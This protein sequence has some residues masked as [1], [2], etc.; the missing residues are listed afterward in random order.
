MPDT[1]TY[2]T[3]S[4]A[5]QQLANRL[6]DSNQV[7]W[8]PAELTSIHTE[9]LRTWNALT[10]FWRGDFIFSTQANV[11]WYDLTDVTNLP[12][13][14]RPFTLTDASLYPD[15]QFALLEPAVGVNPWIG[16]STQ[17][18][19]ADL[20]SALQRRR[21]EI[22][23]VTGC[24]TTKRNVGAV[25]G[26]IT[27]PD[28]VIDVRRMAYFPAIG[29]PSTMWPDDTWAEQSFAA[30]YLQLPAGTPFA[31]LLSTEPPIS[32][33]TDRAPNAAGSYE[34]LTVESGGAVTP[35][36][37]TPLFI[38]DDWAHVLKWGVLA[39][40]LGRESNAKDSL[41][42]GYCEQRY[43]MGLKLLAIAPAL[44]ALRIGNR[45]LQ[46]DSVRSADLYRA[47]WQAEAAG[48]PDMA[49]HSGLNLI[50]LAAKPDAGPYSLTATVVE[51]A[52]IPVNAIAKVQ[53]ARDELEAVLDYAQH[54]A[55]FKMGGQEFLSTIPLFQRFMT[56]AQIYNSKLS[57]M[58]EYTSVLYAL[59]QRQEQ[60]APR[61]TPASEVA[62]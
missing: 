59:S 9:S 7:F 58:G 21:D 60:M 53:V 31:Y 18:S 24:F 62:S 33:D 35:T 11:T 45:V 3:Q 47:S 57:E 17:F 20:T 27:L 25:A 46:I 38:P 61:M 34:L 19:V 49:F 28:V 56:Q 13:T 48:T 12:N 4:Q 52:P 6:Y 16:A 32:F 29:V 54:I 37:P 26:R 36:T 44:L 2:L 30:N 43:R 40:L 42:A 50:A 15:I 5:V 41:R 23:S 14:L 22:L 55:S 1:Y 39:D 51:N 10:S 8:S